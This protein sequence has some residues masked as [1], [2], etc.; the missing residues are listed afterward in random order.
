VARAKA[1]HNRGPAQKRVLDSDVILLRK[2][3]F[4][5]LGAGFVDLLRYTPLRPGEPEGDMPWFPDGYIAAEQPRDYL[6]SVAILGATKGFAIA[7]TDTGEI[8]AEF[9]TKDLER[10]S[11][12]ASKAKAELAVAVMLSEGDTPEEEGEDDE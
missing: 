4:K 11:N 6:V 5:K 1:I 3:N 7:R 9:E 2:V 12:I 10:A 8:L